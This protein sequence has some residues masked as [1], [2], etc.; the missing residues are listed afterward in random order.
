MQRNYRELE[1]NETIN[2]TLNLER[3]YLI[4]DKVKTANERPILITKYNPR[5][6][7]KESFI[8]TLAF[9]TEKYRMR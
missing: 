2:N 8:E 4:F 5:K 3:K 6:A 1:I 7:I 9:D